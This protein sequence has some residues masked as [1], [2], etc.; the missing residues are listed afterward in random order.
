MKMRKEAL[1]IKKI[2]ITWAEKQSVLKNRKLESKEEKLWS[3][4]Q[5]KLDILDALKQDGGP[6]TCE[7]EVDEYLKC[8][9]NYR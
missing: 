9:K 8:K 4:E 7:E 3:V 1:A 6:F 5:R 2:K